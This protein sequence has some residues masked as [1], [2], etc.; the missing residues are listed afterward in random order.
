MPSF[1]IT[2]MNWSVQLSHSMFG[3][4][5]W[6]VVSTLIVGVSVIRS[7]STIVPV[8]ASV[9]PVASFGKFAGGP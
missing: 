5:T 7:I 2:C 1:V 3:S 6:T 9:V 4:V 8:V